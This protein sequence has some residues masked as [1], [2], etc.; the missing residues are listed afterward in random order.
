[1]LN[2]FVPNAPF[3]YP[4]KTSENLTVLLCFQEVEKGCIGKELVN[5]EGKIFNTKEA[6]FTIHE[7]FI[8]PRDYR[9]VAFDQPQNGK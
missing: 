1:M 7:A 2:L 6:F 3:L 9:D 8:R 4:Q 5:L